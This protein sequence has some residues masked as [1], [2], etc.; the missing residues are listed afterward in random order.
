MSQ[1][2]RSSFVLAYLLGLAFFVFLILA[3]RARRPDIE[4]RVGP[5]PA[6]P[7]F[8]SWLVPPIILV[9]GIGDLPGMWLPVRVLGV[10]LG[11]YALV[12][13]PWAAASLGASYAPGPALL[14]DQVLVTTGPYQS[15]RHPIYS[16][17]V[18]LWL[19]A[20]LG[21]LNWLL[22]VLWAGVLIGVL[23]QAQIEEKLLRGHFGAR[24]D[25]YAAATGRLFP[26]LTRSA[27]GAT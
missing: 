27:Q 18:A 4:Q 5:L 25:A 15:I 7:A 20:A 6:P 12:L 26:R 3:F 24:Y 14:R 21:T 22:L 23:K 16:A 1:L 9:A 17:V 19:G 8:I 2:F 11:L 13:I 10:A